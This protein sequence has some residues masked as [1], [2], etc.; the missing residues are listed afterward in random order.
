MSPIGV[1]NKINGVIMW[2]LANVPCSS[3]IQAPTNPAM[4][5]LKIAE[6]HLTHIEKLVSSGFTL[7]LQSIPPILCVHVTLWCPRVCL[8]E[9]WRTS[10]CV[11]SFVNVCA[12]M[13]EWQSVSI[14]LG[15]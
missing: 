8:C 11:S 9:S 7:G 13:R 3:E 15:V 10:V 6:K 2:K 5:G 14:G 12:C 1:L 4:S